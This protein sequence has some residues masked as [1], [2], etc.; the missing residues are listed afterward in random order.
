MGLTVQELFAAGLASSTQKAYKSGERR[1]SEFCTRTGVTPFPTKETT[2]SAFVAHLYREGLAASTAKSYLA[3]VRHAQIALGLGDPKMAGMP[4]LEYVTKGLRKKTAGRHKRTR[5]PITPPI[6]RQLKSVWERMPCQKDASMLWAASCLCFFGFLRMGEA[7]V[8]S[9]T[10][11]DPMVHLTYQDVQAESRSQPK[12]ITV[13][14]KASKTDPFRVGV[15][16]YVGATGKWLCPVAA[17]LAYMVQRGSGRGPLFQ[18]SD[19]RYLTRPRFI[20]ALRTALRDAGIDATQF[21]GHSF[22]IGAATTASLCGIQDSMIQTLGRW[23]SAAY[24]L[25]I[26]TPPPTLTAVSKSLTASV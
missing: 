8:P 12:W 26:Q 19:G 10:E 2:L 3:A 1:Y 25:Y 7:V 11:F 9:D 13:R 23:R 16:I 22:R 6:L 4:Q 20:M 21:A 17:V 18:F 15:T 14:I 24:T 5:L